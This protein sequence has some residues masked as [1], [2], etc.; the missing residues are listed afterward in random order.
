MRFFVKYT[1][2]TENTWNIYRDGHVQNLRFF[3]VTLQGQKGC[4]PM[5]FCMLFLKIITKNFLEQYHVTKIIIF[6]M[7]FRKSI[8]KYIGQHLFC[9]RS[10]TLKNQGFCTWPSLNIYTWK[11]RYILLEN[12]YFCRIIWFKTVYF[13]WKDRALFDQT[14]LKKNF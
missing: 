13:Q 10:G 4:C 1:I 11:R 9:P 5:Y 12:T 8:W 6:V 3:K 2:L 14:F 7:I